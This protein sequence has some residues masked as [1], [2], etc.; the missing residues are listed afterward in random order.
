[1]QKLRHV[2][3][4]DATACVVQQR[5]GR[6]V[7]RGTDQHPRATTV[8]LARVPGGRC[9][10]KQSSHHWILVVS[11]L[12]GAVWAAPGC[13][14]SEDDGAPSVQNEAGQSGALPEGQG[15]TSEFGSRN[16]TVGGTSQGTPEAPGGASATGTTRSAAGGHASSSTAEPSTG[17]SASSSAAPNT[18]GRSSFGQGQGGRAAQGGTLGTGGSS[19]ATEPAGTGGNNCLECHDREYLDSNVPGWEN[20]P[21]R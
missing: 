5:P 3:R 4:R 2:R 18:G 9:M 15:G 8:L 17:G 11:M 7:L 1:M 21:S 6:L 12:G 19:A 16:V 14:S 20:A 13:A 10:A